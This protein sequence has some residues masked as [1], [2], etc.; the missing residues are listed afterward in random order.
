M[1]KAIAICL[2]SIIICGIFAADMTGV[3]N[4]WL[5]Y[6]A[7][8]NA[9]GNRTTVQGAG[10]GGEASG[11]VRT[12]LIGAAAGAYA[13]NLTDCVGIG[14]RALQGAADMGDVVAIGTDVL[15]GASN[16]HHAV[17][18]GSG[19]SYD[20]QV[21]YNGAVD[22]NGKFLVHGGRA[23]IRNQFGVDLFHYADGRMTLTP[24]DNEERQIFFNVT[25]VAG[26]PAFTNSIVS[27]V[28]S[29][30]GGVSEEISDIWAYLSYNLAERLANCESQITELNAALAAATDR[31]AA[32]EAKLTN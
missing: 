29:N 8:I 12:D 17:F 21:H 27:V 30:I 24:G 18:I 26:T 20:P 28:N 23:I 13:T 7:G 15:R 22:L 4:T 3:Y 31:I 9:D 10:A 1:R 6:I 25:K 11:L 19:V 14:F 16:V 5:G 2:S 32:L